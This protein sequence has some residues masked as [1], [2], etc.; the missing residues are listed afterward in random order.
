[1]HLKHPFVVANSFRV[2]NPK[3]YDFKAVYP[4]F[5]ALFCF[6]LPLFIFPQRPL[7]ISPRPS[8]TTI[9]FCIVYIPAKRYCA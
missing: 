3:R 2:Y 1:M 5:D 7:I 4:A 9:V 8:P 6:F